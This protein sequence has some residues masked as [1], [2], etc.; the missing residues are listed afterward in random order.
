MC[1]MQTNIT[2]LLTHDQRDIL[3]KKAQAL[4][5]KLSPFLRLAAM[6]Y[7]VGS[8]NLPAKTHSSPNNTKD[9]GVSINECTTK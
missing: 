9:K 5:L 6:E 4:G 8:L 3:Q 2:I 1:G 7:K